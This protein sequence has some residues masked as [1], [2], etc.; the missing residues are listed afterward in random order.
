MTQRHVCIKLNYS[1]IVF[2]PNSTYMTLYLP[3]EKL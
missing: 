2:K 1:M 3:D